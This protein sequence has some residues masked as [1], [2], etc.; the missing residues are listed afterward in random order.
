MPDNLKKFLE[1][2]LNDPL[3]AAEGMDVNNARW[4]VDELEQE[5]K[6]LEDVWRPSYRWFSFWY[7][8]HQT[9]HPLIF[10]KEF[11]AAEQIRQEFSSN[12]T[13]ENAQKLL[14]QHGKTL[15]AYINGL[16]GCGEA[17]RTAQKAEKLSSHASF[18]FFHRVITFQEILD[19]FDKFK[20]NSKE[21]LKDIDR[22]HDILAGNFN[23][24]D[25]LQTAQ[26]FI[27]Q[28]VSGPEPSA[29]N[30][31]I[32]EI[33]EK[34]RSIKERYG[35]IFYTLPNFDVS[36]KTHQFFAYILNS[37]R[38]GKFDLKITDQYYYLDIDENKKTSSYDKTPYQPLQRR[39]IHY[40]LQ[41][42]TAWYASFDLSYY[43]DLATICDLTWRRPHLPKN[44]V[45]N[46][47]S[48]M[49][50]LILETGADGIR[51]YTTMS[52]YMA[53]ESKLPPL[54]YLYITRGCPSLYFLPFNRSVWR[55]PQS[56]NFLG[57]KINT[58]SHFKNFAEIA[59]NLSGGEI[60]EIARGAEFRHKDYI[61]TR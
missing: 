5:L 35:P 52:R 4:A 28:I 8:F 60:A 61:T 19:I 13:R 50:D 53:Q 6:K 49:L 1:I 16:E 11:V 56:P 2:T 36:P 25:S 12:S 38:T 51:Q 17:L 59:D 47:K 18:Q 26:D 3:F 7:P 23:L 40:W 27:P 10:L 9:L 54:S 46:Q 55:L 30:K 45:M 57:T 33:L 44:S 31:K 24:S 58:I 20:E 32:L 48:S 37:E 43:A 41:P 39:N 34:N 22:R 29:R 14:T 15:K 42:P 21:L